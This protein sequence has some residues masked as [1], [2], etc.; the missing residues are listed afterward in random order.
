LANRGKKKELRKLPALLIVDLQNLDLLSDNLE[1]TKFG[2][3]LLDF[4]A[5]FDGLKID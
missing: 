3:V 5:K 4:S 2:H 1:V